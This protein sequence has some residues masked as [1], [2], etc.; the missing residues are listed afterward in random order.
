MLL[1]LTGGHVRVCDS[2][3]DY[4]A[5]S[6]KV[7]LEQCYQNLIN[8][9]GRL[10]VHDIRPVQRQTGSVGCGLFAIAFAYELAVGHQPVHL[11]RFDQKKMR[12]H[13]LSCFE[14]RELTHFPQARR[15]PATQPIYNKVTSATLC[16]CKLPEKCN[17][18][19][20]F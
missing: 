1:K 6:T 11:V 13:L 2:R 4:L 14:K 18:A 19:P 7:Q 3:Y 9:S 16:E 8:E 17:C 10:E 5:G 15:Q 20:G 12:S